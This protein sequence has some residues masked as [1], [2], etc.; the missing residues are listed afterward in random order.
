M[1]SDHVRQGIAAK[2]ARGSDR[3]PDRAAR[4]GIGLAE[5][6]GEQAA[7]HSVGAPGRVRK[8]GGGCG[9]ADPALSDDHQVQLQLGDLGQ[10]VGQAGQPGDNVFQ[11]ADIQP[12]S[13][14]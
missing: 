3:R 5:W 12:R 10:I 11:P 4:Q 7:A 6:S 1:T 9:D 13:P 2:D 14:R 8:D